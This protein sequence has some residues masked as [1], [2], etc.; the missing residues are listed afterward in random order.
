MAPYVISLL[1]GA[2]SA[3]VAPRQ[4]LQRARVGGVAVR[5]S[6]VV[7]RAT[8]FPLPPESVDRIYGAEVD[9]AI[10]RLKPFVPEEERNPFGFVP[11]AEKVNGRFCMMGFFALLFLEAYLDKV[12][13]AGRRGASRALA[14]P[15]RAS[16]HAQRFPRAMRR[17]GS[18]GPVATLLKPLTTPSPPRERQRSGRSDPAYNVVRA[19][20]HEVHDSDRCILVLDASSEAHPHIT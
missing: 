6:D 2:A 16:A 13:R 17:C 11:W 10:A 19:T 3:H 18:P 15:A 4:A 7:V 20:E 1:C 12:R 8:P 14:V 5:M 9:A